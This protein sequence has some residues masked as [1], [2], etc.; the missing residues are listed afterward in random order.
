MGSNMQRQDAPLLQLPEPYAGTGMAYKPARD[1]GVTIVAK[2]PGVVERV[3]A[4][5]I[6]VRHEEEVDGQVVKGDLDKYKLIKFARSNQGTCINQ[7]PIVKVGV[8]VEKGDT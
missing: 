7:R 5:E 4:D 1:S 2:R 6:W 3:T 8:R